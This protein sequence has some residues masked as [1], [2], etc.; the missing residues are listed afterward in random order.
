MRRSSFN[1]IESIFKS[2]KQRL[3]VRVRVVVFNATFNNISVISYDGQF[4]WWRKPEKTTDLPQI[5]D[6]LYTYNVASCTPCHDCIGSYKSNCH[7][8]M[9]TMAMY[10]QYKGWETYC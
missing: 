1:E 9:I 3:G 5:T 2:S 6:K 8:I 10:I 7:M 4:H